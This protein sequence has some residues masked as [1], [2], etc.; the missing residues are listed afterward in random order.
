MFDKRID[1]SLVKKHYDALGANIGREYE[2]ERWRKNKYRQRDYTQTLLSLEMHFP[3]VK[4]ERGLEIGPGTGIWTPF[5][6]EA[7]EKIDLLDISKRMLN[8]CRKRFGNQI[9]NY[10]VGDFESYSFHGK[11]LYDIILSVRSFE[12]TQDK[13]NAFKKLF[14][15]LKPG[16][17]LVIVSKNWYWEFWRRVPLIPRLR[18]SNLIHV[19]WLKPEVAKQYAQQSGFFNIKLYPVI[20]QSYIFIETPLNLW[21]SERMFER[22]SGAQLRDTQRKLYES[23]IVIAKKPSC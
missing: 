21:L 13:K 10:L 4:V 16:G 9:T 22:R 2:N 8:L 19:D 23:Y 1:L 15:L 14:H 17:T 11:A 18:R 5:L 7:C 12:Y 20:F 3:K 6:L